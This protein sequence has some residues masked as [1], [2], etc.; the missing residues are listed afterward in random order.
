MRICQIADLHISENRAEEFEVIIDD[1]IKSVN[2]NNVD[3]VI[4]CGDMFVHRGRL[5]PQQVLLARKLFSG[6]KSSN[7][8]IAIPGNHDASMSELKPDSL[9]AVFEQD[10]LVDVYTSLGSFLDIGQYRLHFFP[11]PSKKEMSKYKLNSTVTIFDNLSIDTV[12]TLSNEKKNILI[13]HTILEGA[14]II[15]NKPVDINHL[16]VNYD[17]YIPKHIWDKFDYVFAGHLHNR[18]SI[19]ENVVYSGCPVPLTYIDTQD[20]G[21]VLWE[22]SSGKLA[23]KFINVHKRFQFITEDF[24]DISNIV[25]P[26]QY[27]K[28]FLARK[29]Y[30]DSYVR[31]KY[32]IQK[33][34]YTVISSEE[35]IECLKTATNVQIIPEYLQSEIKS[36]SALSID[37]FKHDTIKDIIDEYIKEH[38][39]SNRVKTVA[40]GIEIEILNNKDI[41]IPGNIHL[42]LKKLDAENFK[43]FKN[44]II[45]FE[46]LN[47]LVGIF[48]KNRTGKSSLVEAI[49]WG[50]FGQTFRNKDIQSVIRNGE[51]STTVTI[52]FISNKKQYKLVRIRNLKQG[53]L[54]LFYKDQNDWIDI[55]GE[56]TKHTQKLVDNLVGSYDVFSS[57]VYSP[58]NGVDLLLKKRPNE[59]KQVIID[60]LNINALTLRREIVSTRKKLLKDRVQQLNGKLSVYEQKKKTV[61][62]EQLHSDKSII[63]SN[64]NELTRRKDV[65]NKKL[66]KLIGNIAQ[67]DN[68]VDE[69]R[70]TSK[71]IEMCN[72]DVEGLKTKI[73]EKTKELNEL[74]SY[75]GVIQEIEL[76]LAEI[77]THQ[78]ELQVFLQKKEKFI[79]LTEALR[80]VTRDQRNQQ[81]LY[82]ER[83]KTIV[84]QMNMIRAQFDGVKLL[85]CPKPDCP[86]NTAIKT[87]KQGLR[88]TFLKLKNNLDEVKK[89]SQKDGVE[90]QK[91]ISKFEMDIALLEYNPDAHISL[92]KKLAKEQEDE[93]EL[94]SIKSR[95][96]SF[97]KIKQDTESLIAVYEKI[98]L[99]KLEDKKILQTKKEAINTILVDTYLKK[100]DL[101]LLQTQA[102]ELE[103]ELQQETSKYNK[104]INILN[105]IKEAS[106]NF[107]ETS[108]ALTY[109]KGC[110]S[111][112]DKYEDIVGSTGIVFS[113]IENIVIPFVE[114]FINNSLSESK[115]PF[116]I[117]IEPFKVMSNNHKV[118]DVMIYLV[119]EKGRR[120]ILEASGAELAIVSLVLRAA[121]A[122]LLSFRTGTHV[123]LFIVDEGMGVFDDQYLS[124]IK[125]IFNQLGT[126]F[127]KILLITHIPELKGIAQ[128]TLEVYNDGLISKIKES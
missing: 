10:N 83:I 29:N 15:D 37:D 100:Q 9:S 55:S 56:D 65:A 68:L 13:C 108:K 97:D 43:C 61:D 48:G 102:S 50:L 32:A 86:L 18:Q 35:I 118:D 46:K 26:L 120:D 63:E 3:Y 107:K 2:E 125:S 40:S 99:N 113:L 12:F 30:T 1:I 114:K 33:D 78:K 89:T 25:N 22:D 14:R 80:N 87:N 69:M 38:K 71:Q 127:Q 117:S 81:F 41:V 90:T 96:E 76:K 72:L 128:S 54:S 5:S 45:D 27:I 88:D 58:Q 19:I 36:T 28:D 34:K 119:D 6:I 77:D 66:T 115:N 31:I 75:K 24:G 93:R 73:N 70:N 23:P 62:E 79:T 121:L 104:T 112:Y 92:A 17:V 105:S 84:D 42:Q 123:E 109:V 52:E 4:F 44:I 122:N 126:I 98:I 95:L 64:I 82:K 91:V 67:V 103:V 7:K 16:L 85:D 20:T 124:I 21:W 59:R 47:T 11:Y 60:C 106:D 57:T 74:S 116:T 111:V 49:V 8:I 39:L 94:V 110:I 53:K 101:T 51:N